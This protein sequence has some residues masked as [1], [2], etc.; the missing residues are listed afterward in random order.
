MFRH[1]YTTLWVLGFGWVGE[2]A[3]MNHAFKLGRIQ[4]GGG[5]ESDSSV[6][7]DETEAV[8]DWWVLVRR[9]EMLRLCNF[10]ALVP[11]GTE[12]KQRPK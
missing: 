12:T 4:K 10:W 5:W 8:G 7:C 1:F 3:G 11:I 9:W 6:F 2:R